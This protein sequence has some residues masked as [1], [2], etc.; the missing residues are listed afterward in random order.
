MKRKNYVKVPLEDGMTT[1]IFQKD[2]GN[3]MMESFIGSAGGNID[4][5]RFMR[6]QQKQNA[7][8]RV[9]YL[10]DKLRRAREELRGLK[11]NR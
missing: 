4:A 10:E 6:D 11:G 1:F 5:L 3:W 2:D 9:A 7:A 8:R